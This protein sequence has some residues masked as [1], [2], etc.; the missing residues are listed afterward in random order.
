MKKPNYKSIGFWSYL[1]KYKKKF[2][3]N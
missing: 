3:R 1:R 2:I